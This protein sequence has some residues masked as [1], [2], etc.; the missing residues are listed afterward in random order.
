AFYANGKLKKVAIA[1]GP[2]VDLCTATLTGP[3]AWSRDGTILFPQRGDTL[4]LYRVSD[5][6]GQPIRVTTGAPS[7]GDRSWPGSHYW[8]CFLPDGRHFLYY[9]GVAPGSGSSREI[10]LG[11]L[12][13]KASR[14]VAQLDSR[15]EY[16]A[17]GYL[18]YVREGTLIVQPFDARSGRLH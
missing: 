18:A 3:G 9:V 7:E 2:P 15:V 4:G 12:D 6:G 1:G 16:V 8:P 17:P 5:A 11:S 14:V 13:S 10:R